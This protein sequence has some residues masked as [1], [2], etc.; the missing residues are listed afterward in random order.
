[1]HYALP[2]KHV[3]CYSSNSYKLC[4]NI[5]FLLHLKKVLFYCLRLSLADSLLVHCVVLTTQGRVNDFDTA[6][7]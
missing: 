6:L 4:H 2:I 3:T 7:D 5:T 1:M